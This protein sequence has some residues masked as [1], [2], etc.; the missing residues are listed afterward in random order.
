VAQDPLLY[1]NRE[2]EMEKNFF[3]MMMSC[4]GFNRIH[5]YIIVIING[6]NYFITHDVNLYAALSLM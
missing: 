6:V 2:P 1:P 4:S 3:N 5:Q